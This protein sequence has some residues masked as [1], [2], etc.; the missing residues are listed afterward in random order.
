VDGPLLG[1]ISP[2]P[3]EHSKVALNN[4]ERLVMFTD[5]IDPF[6]VAA[7]GKTPGWFQNALLVANKMDLDKAISSIRDAT[8]KA[9]GPRPSDDW[10]IAVIE[11]A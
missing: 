3:Y 11:R 5:G 8:E 10:L 7:A 9:L 2:K 1:V 4:D 6:E